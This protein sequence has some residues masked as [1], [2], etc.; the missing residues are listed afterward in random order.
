MPQQAAALRARYETLAGGRCALDAELTVRA[1][2]ERFL[3]HAQREYSQRRGSTTAT[4]FRDAMRQA[5]E[6]YADLPARDFGPLQLRAV[7]EYM[8]DCG[9]AARTINDRIHRIRQAWR[10]A[11]T[12]DLVD[13]SAWEALRSLPCIPCPA[14][15]AKPVLWAD[16]EPILFQVRPPV[17][18]MIRLQW[19]SGMRPGEICAMRRSEV[20]TTEAPWV[21]CPAR[22]K[23]A[24]RG[25]RRRV[26]LGPRSVE[27]LTPWLDVAAGN[28]VF[29][30]R[31]ASYYNAIRRACR[32]AGVAHWTPHQLRHSFATRVERAAGIKITSTLLSHASVTTTRI[33]VEEDEPRAVAAIRRLG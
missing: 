15:D 31:Q 11:V 32:R 16:V 33:Y 17:A 22:H 3:T 14:S 18:A 12:L 28:E 24:T 5:L 25:K 2:Y 13:S 9:Y 7:R 23:T 20:D 4:N 26:Y 10:W 6:L 29:G 19:W 27:I 21:Y 8:R 30:Y 1:L